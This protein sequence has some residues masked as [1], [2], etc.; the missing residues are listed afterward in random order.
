MVMIAVFPL[1]MI[2]YS[3]GHQQKMEAE[4]LHISHLKVLFKETIGTIAA[5][6]RYKKLMVENIAGMAQIAQ[7]LRKAK[8]GETVEID[9]SLETYIERILSSYNLYDFFIIDQY[10]KVIY[11][12]KKE[13]DLGKKINSPLLKNTGLARAYTRAVSVLDASVGSFDYYPPSLRKANFIASPVIIDGKLLGVVAV[14]LNENTIYDLVKHYSGLGQSGEVVA[15]VLKADGRIVPALPLK[16]DADAFTKERVLNAGPY[17]IGLEPA[18]RGHFGAGEI[19]DYRGVRCV[20]VWGYEPTLGWGI[21]V[22]TDKDEVLAGVRNDQQKLLYLFMFVAVGIA[23]LI[24]LSVISIT[25]PIYN[26]IAS[27]RKFRKGEEFDPRNID[28]RGEICYLTEEF[29]TMAE[30]IQSYQKDLEEKIDLRTRELQQAKEE[31]EAI[32]ITDQLTG[33]YNRRHLDV[34]LEQLHQ[35]YERYHTPFSVAIFDIDYFKYINDSFGHQVGDK[36]LCTIADILKAHSRTIDI[37]GRWGG[38]EFLIIY[39]NLD[40]PEALIAAK[41]LRRAIATKYFDIAGWVTIS[42]GVSSYQESLNNTLKRADDALYLAKNEGRD[43]VC[44]LNGEI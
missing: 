29:N 43:Q 27:I 32:S 39:P 9:S 19:F 33:L 6:V 26:L 36:V 4:T 20:A 16:Y 42:G 15:G 17:Q 11:T 3:L 14:Q 21:V 40:E 13:D 18:V 25:R 7:T 5:H 44:I 38:E 34:V 22:K 10:G 37:V 12:Y 23:L 35:T 28:C 2:F 41:N 30:E 8:H 31:I 24:A 1:V